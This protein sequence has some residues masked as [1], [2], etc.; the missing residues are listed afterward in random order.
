MMP[1][2]PPP[3]D[4]SPSPFVSSLLLSLPGNKTEM[5]WEKLISSD[6][7][8]FYAMTGRSWC[9]KSLSSTES[10]R[11][12]L[13]RDIPFLFHPISEFVHLFPDQGQIYIFQTKFRGFSRHHPYSVLPPFSLCR[14]SIGHLSVSVSAESSPLAEVW[15]FLTHSLQGNHS[16]CVK[17]PLTSK[18]RLRFSTWASY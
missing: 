2:P 11:S 16:G 7:L 13:K 6:G 12:P 1:T 14:P 3:C 5:E 10:S 4:K 9:G 8:N 18:Q 15:P 17:P